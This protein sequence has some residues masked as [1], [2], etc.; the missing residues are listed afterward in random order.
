MSKVEEMITWVDESLAN[1]ESDIHGI[2]DSRV[3]DIVG[4]STSHFQ[5]FLNNLCSFSPVKY[6]E[7][8]T[9]RGK[10]FCGAAAGNKNLVAY[11]VDNFIEKRP[12]DS[13]GII[14]SNIDMVKP[15][16]GELKF[17]NKDSLSITSQDLD[18]NR[19][20]IFMYDGDHEPPFTGNNFKYFLQYMNDVFIFMLDDYDDAFHDAK[21]RRD[22]ERVLPE[23]NLKIEKEWKMIGQGGG[24]GNKWHNGVFIA[25]ISK[26]S[27]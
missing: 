21:V 23:C 14:N 26:L 5:K 11:C 7:I 4:L 8:G 12:E 27:K 18:D 16:S 13:V 3:L 25:V 20:D 19:F 10:M 1:A 2:K 9:F 15:T 24:D 17:I 6:L 22:F